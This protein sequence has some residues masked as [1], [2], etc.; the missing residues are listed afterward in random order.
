MELDIDLLPPPS[1]EER[2]KIPKPYTELPTGANDP[3]YPY[4]YVG[5]W[6]G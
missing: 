6:R 1:D 3:R 2:A 4:T 5:G